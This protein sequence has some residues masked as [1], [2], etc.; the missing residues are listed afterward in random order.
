MIL[1]GIKRTFVWTIVSIATTAAIATSP[2]KTDSADPN[3]GGTDVAARPA[4]GNSVFGLS[5]A[6]LSMT[7]ERPLFSPSRRPPAPPAPPPMVRFMEPAKPAEPDYP[8]L[9]LV[10]TV[11]GEDSDIAVFIEQ[12]TENT[13]K[14]RVNEGHQGWILR[15]IQGREVTL[16]KDRKSSTLALA[17]PGSVAEPASSQA[18]LEPPKRLP[19]R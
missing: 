9:V 1:H 10:G 17:P 6:K 3:A 14:L 13:V 18:A 8:P 7:R 19:R 4:A 2:A 15:S 5:L 11:A 16:L 12:S